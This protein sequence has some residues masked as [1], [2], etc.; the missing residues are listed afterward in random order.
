[1]RALAMVCVLVGLLVGAQPAAAQN[2]TRASLQ[3]K[4]NALVAADGG[5]PGAVVTVRRGSRTTVLTS[6]VSDVAS[7]R[8]PRATDRM[9][10]ASVA[11]TYNGA[12][13]LRLVAQGRLGLGA[14]IGEVLP[15]LPRAWRGVTVRPLMNHTSGVPDY[16]R[17]DGF[18]EQFQTD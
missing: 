11:K 18:R 15:R 17:S 2:D 4:L 6:G 14:T 12:V 16:T 7:G 3:Q 1:M 13:V 10:I 5:P 8:R 9:R